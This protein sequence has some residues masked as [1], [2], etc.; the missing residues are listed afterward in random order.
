MSSVRVCL[1]CKTENPTSAAKCSSCGAPLRI[2]QTV[3]L[4]KTESSF[5]RDYNFQEVE[6]APGKVA[7]YFVG[8]QHPLIIRAGA[9]VILGRAGT[10][11]PLPVIDLTE[12]RAGL[13]GVS[14]QHAILR[15]IPDGYV[16]EDLD[17]TNG[18]F[19]NEERVTS[20]APHLLQNSDQIRLGGL[21]IFI[22]FTL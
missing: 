6:L 2:S 11:A 8:K 5:S 15:P 22:R 17:S 13:L 19:V 4:P 20:G 9:G 18:T 16:I 3:A 14:R 12:Y 21:V 1:V 10:E 7:L